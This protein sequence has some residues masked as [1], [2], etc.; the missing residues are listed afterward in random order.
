MTMKLYWK[1]ENWRNFFKESNYPH[2]LMWI[3]L[4]NNPKEMLQCLYEQGDNKLNWFSVYLYNRK[5]FN[6]KL[7]I[8]RICYSHLGQSISCTINLCTVKCLTWY[9]SNGLEDLSTYHHRSC[10][11]K[12]NCKRIFQ[13]IFPLPSKGDLPANVRSVLM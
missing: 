11:I 7:S 10:L 9:L 4:C 3:S 1:Q 12:G 6:F 13:E 8:M 2:F 5:M